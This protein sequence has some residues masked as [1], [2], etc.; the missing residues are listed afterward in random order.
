MRR[1]LIVAALCPMF[2]AAAAA[3]TID[4]SG[5]ELKHLR[6]RAPWIG[7]EEGGVTRPDE[8]SR[9]ISGALEGWSYGWTA[10]GE[11][12]EMIYF[13][14]EQ[15]FMVKKRG[16]PQ[17][18]THPLRRYPKRTPLVDRKW[19]FAG[20]MGWTSGDYPDWISIPDDKRQFRDFFDYF[21]GTI[22]KDDRARA[23][24]ALG[25]AISTAKKYPLFS[26]MCQHKE[27]KGLVQEYEVPDCRWSVF[28]ELDSK[29]RH[30]LQVRQGKGCFPD[31]SGK[32]GRWTVKLEK[33]KRM[34]YA[35]WEDSIDDCPNDHRQFARGWLFIQESVPES[36]PDYEVGLAEFKKIF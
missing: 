5:I 29:P 16:T 13:S 1:I 34:R 17:N 6:P 14:L 7:F 23:R 27:L 32:A 31:P 22:L 11:R 4:I 25:F 3:E 33:S 19:L 21:V 26:S 30:I 9:S 24:Y 18:G 20:K 35:E 15:W 28:S 10:G 12:G 2:G 8:D 36:A